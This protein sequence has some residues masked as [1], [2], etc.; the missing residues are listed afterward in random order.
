[1]SKFS[2]Q[3]ECTDKRTTK[4]CGRESL[5][6][7]SLGGVKITPAA[8]YFLSRNQVSMWDLL[9]RYVLSDWGDLDKVAWYKTD[10]AVRNGERIHAEYALP[11]GEKVLIVTDAAAEDGERSYTILL[12]QKDYWM[13]DCPATAH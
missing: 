6:E 11:D 7:F 1:M 13:L 9:R 10:E 12:L 2:V 4:M 5:R 8:Q 3:G